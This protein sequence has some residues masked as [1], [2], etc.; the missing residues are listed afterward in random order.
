[1]Q[2]Q[3]L[4]LVIDQLGSEVGRLLDANAQKDATIKAYSEEVTA[5]RA[6]LSKHEEKL[7]A[8]NAGK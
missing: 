2:G 5:L 1:M 8:D 4:L 3:G 6:E 7:R